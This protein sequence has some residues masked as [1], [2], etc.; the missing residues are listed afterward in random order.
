MTVLVGGVGG[1]RFLTGVAHLLRLG[2]FAEGRAPENEITAI[3]NVGDDAWMHGMRICPDLDTCMYTLADVVDPARGWGHRD[4]T[5]GA[6]AELKEYAAQPDWFSLG[7]RDLATHLVR[8]EMLR[9]GVPLSAATA[10][11][12]Q[13]WD[14]GARLLPATDD[15][16]ETFVA[17]E[18]APAIHFQ[19]WW[20]RYRAET[21][22]KGFLMVGATEAVP[23]PGVEA[24]ITE[25]DVVFLAPSN[26]IVSVGPILAIPGITNALKTTPAPV[27]GYS[28]IIAG[29][30]LRGMAD[31]CLAIMGVDCSS[32]G[33]ARHFGARANGGILDGWFVAEEDR[34]DVAG[35][36]VRAIPLLM[37]DPPSA[38]EM[39]RAGLALAGF[40]AV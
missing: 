29:R 19:E 4:E 34:A 39:V 13:R 1:A 22:A 23:A 10:K 40:A 20:V 17:M 33:V 3:V 28:P 9:S 32:E 30:P 35:V 24:A 31:K 16:S 5:W 27:I 12:C 38:A 37:L 6:M 14:L 25:A 36:D 7:D 2:R 26:P 18:S 15:R 21:A 11:L 8:S